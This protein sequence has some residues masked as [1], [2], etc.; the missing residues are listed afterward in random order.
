MGDPR[1]SALEGQ[2]LLSCGSKLSPWLGSLLSLLSPGWG[3][4]DSGLGARPCVA[5]PWF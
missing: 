5:S 4:C 1:E 3:D 2:Q